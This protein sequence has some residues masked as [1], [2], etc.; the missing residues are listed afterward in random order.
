[1]QQAEVLGRIQAVTLVE[2]AFTCQ[3]LL[4]KLVA[5]FCQFNLTSLFV[6]QVVTF[7]ALF[8]FLR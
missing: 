3:Q 5:F 1:M 6:N 8:P 4:N 2:H 7:N